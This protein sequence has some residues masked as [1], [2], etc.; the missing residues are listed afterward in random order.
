L[1]AGQKGGDLQKKSER[2]SLPIK[3]KLSTSLLAGQRARREEILPFTST[4]KKRR[5]V[6]ASEEKKQKNAIPLT[7]VEGGEE[8]S[9][10]ISEPLPAE[11]G[12]EFLLLSLK[13]SY[14]RERWSG[15]GSC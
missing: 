15:H 10:M 4:E 7:R 5:E 14:Q 9:R 12:K 2:P 11:K 6:K 8:F 13:G 3:E 1:P